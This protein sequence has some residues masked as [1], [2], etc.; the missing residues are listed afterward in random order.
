LQ[1]LLR[2]KTVFTLGANARMAIDR[3]VYDPG[4]SGG[5]IATSVVR[6]AFRFMSRRGLGN[7]GAAAINSPVATIG[8]RGTIVEGVVGPEALAVLAD[9]PG[10]DLVGSDPE[11]ATLVVLRGP[12]WQT[13]GF[14][15]IG[16]IDVSAGGIK[17]AVETGGSAVLIRKA[18]EAPVGPFTL[19][20]ASYARMAALLG[21]AP[22]N[23]ADTGR[24][25]TSVPLPVRAEFAGNNPLDAID[26]PI[27]LP[28]QCDPVNKV[29][30]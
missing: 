20:A 26:F 12:G 3:F 27:A 6:G 4:R 7:G 13:D 1:I 2:D 30:F 9:Q 28:G 16:A 15:K 22:D 5:E 11:T 18:G 24:S 21:S 17:V 14:D 25:F 29:C 8:V 23:A 10:I 19:S